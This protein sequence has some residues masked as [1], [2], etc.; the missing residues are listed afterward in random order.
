MQ[1]ND[2]VKPWH[3]CGEPAVPAVY[4]TGG[5]NNGCLL[6]FEVIVS[7][8]QWLLERYGSHG[9]PGLQHVGFRSCPDAGVDAASVRSLNPAQI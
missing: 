2:C 9:T 3:Q 6:F 7:S 1:Q 8:V 4:S 5:K